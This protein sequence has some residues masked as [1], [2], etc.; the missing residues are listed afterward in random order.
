MRTARIVA[1][2]AF[3]GWLQI[4]RRELSNIAR[5]KP[6][7]KAKDPIAGGLGS[8]WIFNKDTPSAAGFSLYLDR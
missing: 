3:W 7:C 5:G 4:E 6:T 2:G 8:F 1:G